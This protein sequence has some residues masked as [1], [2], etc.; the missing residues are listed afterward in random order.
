MAYEIGVGPAQITINVGESV[1]ITEI[2]G[3][4]HQ[5]SER[6][7]FFRDT[8]LV[9][10]W[11]V[12]V[13]DR[14]WQE[15]NSAAT[16]PFAAQVVMV[17]PALPKDDSEVPAGSISLTLSRLLDRGGMRETLTV[18]NHNRVP[19]RLSLTVRFSCDFADLFD[20]KAHRIV[21][22]GQACSR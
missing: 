1:L 6:G 14:L 19:V 7:L 4:I 9:S 20:V 11:T 13:D 8:R 12:T 10:A 2:D 15:L 22:R 21:T 5:P 18:R 3:Q 17:N 16:D